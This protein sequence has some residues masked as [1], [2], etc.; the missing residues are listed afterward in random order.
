[1]IRALVGRVAP[2][3]LMAVAVLAAA[4]YVKHLH[5]DRAALRE[6]LAQ[7]AEVAQRWHEQYQTERARGDRLINAFETRSQRMEDIAR[8]ARESRQALD[9]L[10]RR[11]DELRAWMDSRLP[12]AAADWLRNLQRP[13]ADGRTVPGTSGTADKAASSSEE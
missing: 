6:R 10:E 12:D 9:Q 13:N 1:M 7:E 2:W 3:A 4:L 8:D 5:G 11:D